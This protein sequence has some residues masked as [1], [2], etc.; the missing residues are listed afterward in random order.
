MKLER[1][2]LHKKFNPIENDDVAQ[3]W[4]SFPLVCLFNLIENDD[5]AQVWQ[6]LFSL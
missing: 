6:S 1:M 5:V 4:Q 2:M 3:V